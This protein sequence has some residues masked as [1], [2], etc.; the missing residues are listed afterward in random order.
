MKKVCFRM[1]ERA[2]ID[3]ENPSVEDVEMAIIERVEDMMR[4]VREGGME[5]YQCMEIYT[6]YDINPL[7]PHCGAKLMPSGLGQ[8]AFTC[9]N[10]D[11][12]FFEI[13]CKEEER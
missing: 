13:E 8:Y 6:P 12:D 4:A 7:C 11:E 2:F 5:L 1:D 10:C 9:E 3:K